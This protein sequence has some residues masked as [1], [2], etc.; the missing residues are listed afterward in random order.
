MLIRAL[1]LA[2]ITRLSADRGTLCPLLL[3]LLSMPS[4]LL[5][6]MQTLLA[7]LRFCPGRK[8]A[9]IP[10]SCHRS[11]QREQYDLDETKIQEFAIW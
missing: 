5:R 11:S 2:L 9:T 1:H 6:L 10:T 3:Q 4:S 8:H 7:A